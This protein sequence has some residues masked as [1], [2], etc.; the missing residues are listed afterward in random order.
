MHVSAMNVRISIQK[1]AVVTDKI[2]NHK[3]VWADYY[4][5][6][7]TTSAKTGEKEGEETAQTVHAERMDFT[8]RYSSET[9]A[10]TPDGFRI[11]LGDR[12]YN[13]ISVDDM[14]FKHRSLKF[15]AELVRR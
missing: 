15:H 11:L 14:A 4:S 2:G 5:C 3:N 1:N 9:A 6:Y 10:I 13:I 7:A 8:V 12:I